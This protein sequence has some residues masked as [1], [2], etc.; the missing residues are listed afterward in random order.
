MEPMNHNCGTQS[1]TFRAK[2]LAPAPQRASNSPPCGGTECR[3]KRGAQAGLTCGQKPHRQKPFDQ[4]PQI[5][6]EMQA[7]QAR[8]VIPVSACASGSGK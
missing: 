1:G 4:N 2:P 7:R 6:V 8:S 5:L 3:A